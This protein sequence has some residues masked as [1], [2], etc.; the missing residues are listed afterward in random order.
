MHLKGL[1]MAPWKLPR[2]ALKIKDGLLNK[3]L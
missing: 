1:A 3:L 2:A